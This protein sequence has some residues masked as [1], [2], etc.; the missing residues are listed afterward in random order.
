MA[1]V[2]VSFLVQQ[3]SD[4]TELFILSRLY[5]LQRQFPVLV[6]SANEPMARLVSKTCYKRKVNVENER[7]R[8]KSVWSHLNGRGCF[9]SCKCELDGKY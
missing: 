9:G 3:Q 1:S 2:S 6:P 5:G 4:Y 8:L 7:S